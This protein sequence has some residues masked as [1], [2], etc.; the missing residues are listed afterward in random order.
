MYTGYL[1]TD[2]ERYTLRRA[3]DIADEVQRLQENLTEIDLQTISSPNM[4]GM[5]KGS[6]DGDAMTRRIIRRDRIVGKMQA[7]QRELDKLRTI[8][9]AALKRTK[10]PIRMFCDAYYLQF[11]GLEEACNY[12]RIDKR[13]GERYCAMINRESEDGTGIRRLYGDAGVSPRRT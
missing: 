9:S 1:L 10:T 5:P 3:R 4:D 11:A 7:A 6:G 8:G 2:R 13:T 12:A